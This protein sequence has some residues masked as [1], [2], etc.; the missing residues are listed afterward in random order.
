[1]SDND[2]EK[3]ET[4]LPEEL[5][6]IPLVGKPLFPGV[7]T[8]IMIT[9]SDDMEIIEN[10]MKTNMVIGL[11]LI[12]DENIEIPDSQDLFEIGTVAK[13]V[14]KINLPDGG[15]NIFI[16]TVKRF[17]VKKYT[18]DNSPISAIVEYLD[19]E[20]S[21]DPDEIKA[22]TRSLIAE[23]KTISDNNPLFSEEMRLNMVN[24][25]HPG[26]IADFITSILNIDRNQQQEILD[27]INIKDRMERVLIYIK[28]EQE[29]LRIQRKL[30]AQIN[31][32]IEKSQRDYFLR[33]EIKA[34]KRELG[35][36]IDSKSSEHLKFKKKIDDFNFSGEVK[37]QVEQELEK[38]SLMDPSSSEFIVTR[39]YL[40]TIVS[41]PWGDVQAEKIDIKK[42]TEILDEDHY[43][44]EDVK[45]RIIEYL[46]V[47]KLKNDNK[48]S[49]VCLVGP[50][51][52]GKTSIGKSIA[53][54]LDRKFFRFSVGGMRDEAEIKGHRRTYVG[55]M[56]GKLI[57]GLKI[58]KSKSPVFMIDEIDKLAS[59]HQGDPS[60]AL[61][62]A[63]DP[64]QNIEF[65]DHYLDLPFD[66]SHIL[67]IC[68]ANTLDSIPRPLMDRMEIIRLA[69]YIEDE[70][71]EIAKK[72]LIPKSL[73]KHG[74][75]P[76][77]I[78]YYK[79]ALHAIA[80]GYARDAGMRSFEKAIDRIHRKIAHKIVLEKGELPHVI[81][82]KNL[83]E[84]LKKA[85][86]QEDV[87]KQITKP[88]MTV[89]LAWT[90]FG[91]DTLILEAIA[92][93]GK[94][95]LKLTG[96]MGD[97]MKESAD[98][99][100]SYIKSICS[101][102][103]VKPEFFE[104][105]II[106]LHIPEG[107]TPKDGPSAGITMATAFLSLITGKKVKKHLAMTGEL[108]LTGK[109]LPIG[110]LKEKTIAARRNKIKVIIIPKQNERDLDDIPEK[111]KE[112]ISFHPVE[113]IDEVFKLVF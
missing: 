92:L 75:E 113:V 98:I 108:S 103:D 42:G 4:H 111:V 112:G 13:I 79:S 68:T 46:S 48:G 11:L 50:P 45:E 86:F 89:G 53:K 107:A 65:R 69:G 38:F 70:K 110:G 93:P 80:D 35:E 32:K 3:K 23:M 95:G 52:V 99:A 51:G 94:G 36:P 97:V 33:E 71:I 10:A 90:N 101:D 29:L 106:H 64:E 9:A 109:V 26:K 55:A 7:F 76:K 83:E 87:S 81:E 72:Y 12:K 37:E 84:Y 74:L 63:L 31:D 19:D 18:A 100:F 34:I 1:M 22:M 41:L 39:N 27:L 6:I 73:K 49:I 5:L 30:T 8:P 66:L 56:P 82:K 17:R 96:Q 67:F 15:I 58:V 21:D 47:R 77:H 85:P 91:G 43:G 102:Y 59:S 28:K 14:K 2:I 60:S 16:S 78:R 25:D 88:G 44:L 54:A 62:E 57:Q 24:V 105:H 40:D 104:K 61:L 20:E